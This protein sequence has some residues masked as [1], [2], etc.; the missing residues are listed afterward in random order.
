MKKVIFLITSLNS[1]GI[2]NYLFRFLKHFEGEFIPFIVC[3]NGC[4]GELYEDYA[5]IKGIKFY[6][7]A[8]SYFNPVLFYKLKKFISTVNPDSICDFTGNFAGIP[9]FLSGI[10]GVKNRIAFYRGSTDHFES[11]LFKGIFNSIMNY[12]VYKNAT[13]ILAN[14]KSAI[15]YFFGNLALKDKRIDVI[16]NGINAHSF[17]EIKQ[18]LR[19]NLNIDKSKFVVVHVGRFDKAKNHSTIIKVAKKLID[20][21]KNYV[22]V[23]CGKN[24]DLEF[25]IY[26]KNNQLENNV[27]LLGYTKQVV[28]VLNTANCFYFPSITEGQPNALIEAL[29]K[30]LPFVASNIKPISDVIPLEY[31]CQL[32]DPLDVDLAVKK[33]KEIK[34]NPILG[35]SLNLSSWATNNFDA[36]KLFS[37]FKNKLFDN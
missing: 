24:V 2:E 29:V 14:S 20:L 10:I 23:L 27:K 9:L 36:D 25:Q 13:H 1:G 18:D 31:H 21:D 8:L 33:I 12:L 32:I 6:D 5:K 7:G 34:D 17:L 3:K 11:S 26:V 37:E 35:E 22:F 15:S 30:G 28:K 16:H 19:E 4:H